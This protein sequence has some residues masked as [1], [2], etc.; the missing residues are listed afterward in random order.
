MTT[1]IKRNARRSRSNALTRECS[2]DSD[3]KSSPIVYKLSHETAERS[4]FF[5]RESARFP[6]LESSRSPLYF[7][8]VERISLAGALP[9]RDIGTPPSAA[10]LLG[11]K[12]RGSE[13]ARETFFFFL[14]RKTSALSWPRYHGEADSGRERL[15]ILRSTLADAI[16]YRN[17]RIA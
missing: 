9:I 8:N 12:W 11:Q 7:C 13:G 14:F 5:Y 3:D 2:F 15:R 6:G 17:E 16:G 1:E 4:I 10:K